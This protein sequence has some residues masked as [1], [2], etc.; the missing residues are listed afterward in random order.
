MAEQVR[1][2]GLR[3]MFHVIDFAVAQSFEHELAVVFEGDPIHRLSSSP[4]AD[5][6]RR[7]GRQT[8]RLFQPI[9]R[10][11]NLSMKFRQGHP[12]LAEMAIVFGQA[13]DAGLVSHSQRADASPASL[14]PGKHYRRMESPVWLGAMAGRVATARFETVD[15]AFDQLSMPQNSGKMALILLAKIVQDLP[16]AAGEF[17][18]SYGA[19]PALYLTCCSHKACPLYY[20]SLYSRSCWK[21]PAKSERRG[22]YFLRGPNS[23]VPTIFMSFMDIT[24]KTRTDARHKTTSAL[25][26][27]RAADR[28]ILPPTVN[29]LACPRR[30]ACQQ[31]PPNYLRLLRPSR[32]RRNP[33]KSR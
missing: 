3:N 25:K 20:N 27:F 5:R 1:F 8:Q 6:S 32:V 16:L 28:A 30:E 13:A 14:T 24:E 21:S 17:G 19:I 10:R 22:D 11:Q 15:G 18:G 31:V 9:H 7:R 23:S 29:A 12:A 4:V 2:G 33:V 26:I